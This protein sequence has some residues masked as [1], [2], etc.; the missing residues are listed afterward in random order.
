ML[1]AGKGEGWGVAG[2]SHVESRK[3][4]DGVEARIGHWWLPLLY[5]SSLFPSAKVQ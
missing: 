3:R 2:K 4:G 1:R 5:L